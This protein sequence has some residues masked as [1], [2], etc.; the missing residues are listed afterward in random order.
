[1][2]AHFAEFL[3]THKIFIVVAVHKSNPSLGLSSRFFRWLARCILVLCAEIH[4]ASP[5]LTLHPYPFLLAPSTASNPW[6]YIIGIQQDQTYELPGMQLSLLAGDDEEGVPSRLECGLL[7]FIAYCAPHMRAAGGGVWANARLLSRDALPSPP[8]NALQHHVLARAENDDDDDDGRVFLSAE[9]D[10][11]RPQDAALPLSAVAA[12]ADTLRNLALS[13]PHIPVPFS[14]ASPQEPLPEAL[15]RSG[16]A[17]ATAK[18][19]PI[20]DVLARIAH[21]ESLGGPAAYVVGYA[22][23]FDGIKELR[24]NCW[25]QESTD[26]EWVPLHRVRYVRRVR[27]GEGAGVDADG[28]IVWSREGRLDTVFGSGLSRGDRRS[29][30]V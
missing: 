2:D 5:D 23:R 25:V 16:D 4:A 1:M 11:T 3:Q 13:D 24:A 8:S 9:L 6:R 19:R 10:A 22:D 20:H 12:L 27:R 30:E 14:R 18:L 7:S 15:R 21:D 28:E 17:A 29:A 26:E